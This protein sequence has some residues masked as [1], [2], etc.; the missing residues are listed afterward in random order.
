L[1]RGI[2]STLIRLLKIQKKSYVLFVRFAGCRPLSSPTWG[3][4]FNLFRLDN[5]ETNKI[6]VEN[7]VL[8]Q[9]SLLSLS[10]GSVGLY[11]FLG[12]LRQISSYALFIFR[13]ILLLWA[14]CGDILVCY[15][16][17]LTLN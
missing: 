1:R 6:D 11:I 4:R 16:L 14:S 15:Q 2:K 5:D 17:K 12:A 13:F 8:I 3:L 7:I 10:A 9:I